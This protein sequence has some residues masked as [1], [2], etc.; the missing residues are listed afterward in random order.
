MSKAPLGRKPAWFAGS[1]STPSESSSVKVDGINIHYACWGDISQPGVVLIHGSNAHL[2]WWR[3]V[4]PFLADQF[5]VVA[6]D[7]SGMAIATGDPNTAGLRMPLR[8]GVLSTRKFPATAPVRFW[9]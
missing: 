6:L 2:E 4:A 8:L 3:F 5:R 1:L 7:L 9:P